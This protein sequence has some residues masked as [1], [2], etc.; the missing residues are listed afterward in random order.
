[1]VWAGLFTDHWE[2]LTSKRDAAIFGA[3]SAG[4]AR[5][6]CDWAC[7]P[8][9]LLWPCFESEGTG[10]VVN[11]PFLIA[12]KAVNSAAALAW[13]RL[14]PGAAGGGVGAVESPLRE[15]ICGCGGGDVPGVTVLL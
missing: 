12:A 9:A 13:L 5:A 11:L 10:C 6:V 1:M 7:V 2:L 8:L 15:V 14:V 4:H 3:A